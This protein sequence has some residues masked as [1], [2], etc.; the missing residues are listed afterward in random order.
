MQ[1]ENKEQLLLHVGQILDVS[2]T[3][4]TKSGT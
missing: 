3:Q 1:R 4:P 2:S